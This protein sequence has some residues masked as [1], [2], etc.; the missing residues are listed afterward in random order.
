M[1]FIYYCNLKTLDL[2]EMINTSVVE[3]IGSF[4]VIDLFQMYFCRISGTR[5]FSA[6]SPGLTILVNWPLILKLWCDSREDNFE[7]P[8]RVLESDILFL[9]FHLTIANPF[10]MVKKPSRHWLK[11]ITSPNIMKS[12]KKIETM[13]IQL[14]LSFKASCFYTSYNRVCSFLA[15]FL[16]CVIFSDAFFLLM[17]LAK[18]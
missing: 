5:M 2:M 16:F 11:F 8:N 1:D 12:M 18:P 14:I 13:S 10:I 4:F 3:I 6:P 7:G 9:I 15:S 17:V